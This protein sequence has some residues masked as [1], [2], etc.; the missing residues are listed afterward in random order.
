MVETTTDKTKTGWVLVRI[1]DSQGLVV[2]CETIR[3][4]ELDS[5]VANLTRSIR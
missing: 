3:D 1:T 4:E 5:I 2:F